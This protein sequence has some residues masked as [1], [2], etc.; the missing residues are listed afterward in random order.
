M[1]LVLDRKLFVAVSS[2][3]A[4]SGIATATLAAAFAV[5]LAGTT[6][7]ATTFTGVSWTAIFSGDALVVSVATSAAS[8]LASAF[9]ATFATTQAGST[10]YASPTTFS[11]TFV[12][13]TGVSY[14]N[15]TLRFT[16]GTFHTCIK[17]D[18]MTF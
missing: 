10:T 14:A 13:F 11:F 8:A 15:A 18:T 2:A 4:I 16:G 5:S 9:A 17:S 1:R 12:A 3:F 7:F 6:A